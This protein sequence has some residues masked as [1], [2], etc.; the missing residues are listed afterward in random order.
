MHINYSFRG[1]NS[2]A[3]FIEKH[4]LTSQVWCIQLMGYEKLS[5]ETVLY[6]KHLS[7]NIWKNYW[8]F[9]KYH[10]VVLFPL[11]FMM[12][13]TINLLQ[14]VRVS[15]VWISHVVRKM[16]YETILWN[17]HHG[18]TFIL[19]KLRENTKCEDACIRNTLCHLLN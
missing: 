5:N 2:A 10:A 3:T 17:F 8:M 13:L 4:K 12:D 19:S 1:D 9:P 7:H 15:H 18:R 14:Y 11:T 16:F 6:M